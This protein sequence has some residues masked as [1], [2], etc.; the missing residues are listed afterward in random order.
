VD[1][2]PFLFRGALRSIRETF[3]FGALQR[4]LFHQDALALVSATRSAEANDDCRESAV[5]F[6]AACERRVPP[7]KV[8]QMIEIGATQAKRAFPFHEEQTALRQ[9]F[10]TPRALR[11]AEDVKDNEV[12][13]FWRW[14]DIALV[15]FH[16]ATCRVAQKSFLL[17]LATKSSTCKKKTQQTLS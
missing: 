8:N 15:R 7:G 1:L 5:L 3:F 12:F 11:S 10:A 2:I 6:S 16:L 17:K 13:G 9:L 14:L 4:R